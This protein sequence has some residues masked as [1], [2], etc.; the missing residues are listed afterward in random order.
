MSYDLLSR[1]VG[2]KT[3]VAVLRII[4][5]HADLSARQIQK[6]AEKSWG[7]VKPALDSLQDM[8]VILV[9]KGKWNDAIS[10]N[11]Q[12]LFYEL[13]SE[14]FLTENIFFALLGRKLYNFARESKLSPI[15]VFLFSPTNTLYLV[16]KYSETYQHSQKSCVEYLTEHGMPDG[17][18]F[19]ITQPDAFTT[20]WYKHNSP[21]DYV[22]LDGKLFPFSGLQKAYDFFG[23][24]SEDTVIIP[25]KIGEV[26]E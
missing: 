10:L 12:H 2:S 9:Q 6:K 5:L 18:S 1:I 17:I 3:K 21:V 26:I 13:I 7:A 11:Q 24:N 14:I 15:S 22:L 16:C 4:S 23:I 20:T 25:N 19:E 8:G